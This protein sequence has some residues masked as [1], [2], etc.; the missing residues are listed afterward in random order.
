MILV[1]GGTK[2]LGRHIVEV[3]AAAGHPTVRF[4]RGQTQCELP[5]GVEERLGDRNAD[6][7][8]IVDESW[9]AVVD[10]AAMEPANLERTLE[11]RCKR[12][13]FI[14][15]VSVYTD[16]ATIGMTEDGPVC[17][18]FDPNDEAQRYGGNK[19][20]CERLVR[21][22]FGDRA[23]I[24]RPG[25]IVGPWDHTGRFSYWCERA[26]RGGAFVAPLPADQKVQFVDA[27]DV[28]GFV[29]RAIS[30]DIGGTFNVIGPKETT[31][32]GDLLALCAKAAGERG[33][34]SGKPVWLESSF[35]LE[36]GVKPWSD[37]P[38]WLPGDELQGIL[39]TD[40]SRADAAGLELRT[41][42]ETVRRTMA[43]LTAHPE[44]LARGGLTPERE[45]ELLR[46]AVQA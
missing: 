27:S 44:F 28:A 23:T 42:L 31:T 12:Y 6:V 5:A 26:M 39:Q 41:G 20:A 37:L 21:E 13:V 2:F 10:V 19:V 22:R 36:R 46:E 4:H 25:L 9:D 38:L 17:E 45:A 8:A 7:S 18:T 34:P 14:S 16:S 1:L 11:L 43:F 32:M 30:H 33:A 15:T 29:E 24:L 3:L 35:L 40:R